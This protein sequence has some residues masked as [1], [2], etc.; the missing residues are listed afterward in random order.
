MRWGAVESWLLK[1]LAIN[2]NFNTYLLVYNRFITLVLLLYNHDITETGNGPP[3][4]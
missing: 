4:G 3:Q 2:F 1:M